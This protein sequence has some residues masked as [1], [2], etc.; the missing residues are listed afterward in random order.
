MA[1]HYILLAFLLFNH[2][3]TLLCDNRTYS[4]F[5]NGSMRALNSYPS[6][7]NGIC[8]E[9]LCMMLLNITSIF[10]FNCFRNNQT[11]QIFAEVLGRSSISI[12]VDLTASVYFASSPVNSIVTTTMN[13]L[14]KQCSFSFQNL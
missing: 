14:S 7:V 11:C 3:S 2:L 8:Y 9:C 6:T 13:S 12:S 5:H 4:M 1:M 10:A